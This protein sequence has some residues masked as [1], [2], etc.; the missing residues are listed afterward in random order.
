MAKK[1]PIMMLA[2]VLAGVCAYPSDGVVDEVIDAEMGAPST[3]TDPAIVDD[4][5]IPPPEEDMKGAEHKLK[6][7]GMQYPAYIAPVSTYHRSVA[8]PN[9]QFTFLGFPTHQSSYGLYNG[10]FFLVFLRLYTF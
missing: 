4:T 3:V 8:F 6:G 7:Y 5:T 1:I 9:V 10:I 2:A